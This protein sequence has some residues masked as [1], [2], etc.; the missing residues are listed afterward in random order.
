MFI[1]I[2]EN[3][4]HFAK[5]LSLHYFA[6]GILYNYII[7]L[8]NYKYDGDDRIKKMLTTCSNDVATVGNCCDD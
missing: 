8:Y 1:C 6:I 3:I 5:K 2:S 7:E 4:M